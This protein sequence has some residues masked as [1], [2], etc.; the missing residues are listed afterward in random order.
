MRGQIIM[1]ERNQRR[2]K[3]A[4]RFLWKEIARAA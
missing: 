2:E 1:V 3:E 4:G